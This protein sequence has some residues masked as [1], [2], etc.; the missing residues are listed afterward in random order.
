MIVY[1]PVYF[2]H[3]SL[4]YIFGF[5]IWAGWVVLVSFVVIGLDILVYMLLSIGERMDEACSGECS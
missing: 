3:W 4:A 1:G 5:S 2:I